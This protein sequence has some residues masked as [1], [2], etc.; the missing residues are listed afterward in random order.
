M[1][2]GPGAFGRA[3]VPSGASTG[4]HEAVELRDGDPDRLARQGRAA[5]RSQNVNSE[6]A[7]ALARHRR[8][9]ISARSTRAADR[10]STERR[11]RARLG[12]N[13]ILGCSLAAAKAAAAR[14]GQPALP[15]ARRRRQRAT[16]AGAAAERRQRR[17][18]RQQSP[19]SPG[20]HARPR[21]ALRPS[22]EALRIGAEVFHALKARRCTSAVC[23][24]RRRRGRLRARSRVDARRRSR[25]S[26]SGRSSRAP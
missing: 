24:R 11:T 21:S 15:L 22:R 20:V 12:A 9:T 19:R 10:A 8:R 14:C 5:R 23:D 25:R 4:E 3:A 13:A 18:A 1:R 26:S 2:L 7:S 16:S 6:I 17:G